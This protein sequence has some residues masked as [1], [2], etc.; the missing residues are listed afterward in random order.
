MKLRRINDEVF[1]AEGSIVR[2]GP[3]ETR[4]VKERAATSARRR[5][6]ICA[7]QDSDELL[8]EM[9]IGVA[10]DSYIHPH[11]HTA[12][13]E[14]FHIVEGLVDVV[15]FDDAGAVRDVVKLGAGIP[16][17]SFY[18][19]LSESAFHTLLVRTP[20]LVIH[21]VTNGPFRKDETVLAAF[22]PPEE[23]PPE[24]RAAYIRQVDVLASRFDA[25]AAA[26]PIRSGD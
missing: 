18:Y 4:F 11:R 6:R 16:D 10:A 12:K 24:V 21:E 7:H 3:D 17:R 20:W 19:R 8:H 13:V 15:I 14:S 9:L 25:G 1:V 26:Q 2:F 5:A 23:A 22:A